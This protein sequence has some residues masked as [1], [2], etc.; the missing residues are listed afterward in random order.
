MGQDN[1]KRRDGF[2]GQKLIVIPKK[3]INNTLKSDLLTKPVFITDVGYYPKAK[4]H[5]VERLNGIS[6]HV[7]IYCTE[8]YGWLEINK[9][10]S[11]VSP[12][13]F[14][15]IP[16]NVPH[17]YGA[18]SNKPWTIYWVH[19]K[20]EASSTIIDL[21]LK[22]A[23]HYKPYLTY[24]DDRIKLFQDICINLEIGYH[25]D[26]LRFVNMIF[27]HFLTSLIYEDKFNH[28]ENKDTDIVDKAIWYMQ[29]NVCGLIRLE[30]ISTAVDRS[31]SHLSYVFKKKT[32]Y[33]P[34]E[35]F[36]Q[37]KIQKAC[38]YI[39]LSTSSIKY[40]ALS[41][42][43]EDQYYF[44][45]LFTKQMGISPSEYRKNVTPSHG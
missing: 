6:Q 44:S 3:V 45:R 35:Y 17:K 23:D 15:A 4:H 13:Q 26:N 8:G 27:S 5:F 28:R 25:I 42:G 16:A 43:F 39:S 18:D 2:E 30:D 9:K 37:L 14:I 33:S 38:Q 12:S 24:S 7:I 20:G 32:G 34:V 21:L 31:P 19:F 29:E 41:L 1:I 10:R 22:N 36:N 11:I 40:I